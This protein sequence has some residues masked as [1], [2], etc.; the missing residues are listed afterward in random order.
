MSSVNAKASV[1]AT[2][3]RV[4][5]PF[6][7]LQRQCMTCLLWEDNYYIDGVSVAE[8]IK[9]NMKKITREQALQILHESKDVNHLR[10]LPLYLL[11][12]MAENKM[13]KK[14][15]VYKTITRVDDMAEL[16]S[17]WWK[18]TPNGEKKRP[19]SMSIRKGIQ[20]AF[21]KF[22]EYQFGKYKGN[23]KAMK[24]RDVIRIVRPTP[25][26][27]TQSS[28]WKKIVDGTL[29]VPDTW[30]T[31]LS[32]NGEKVDK[33]ATWN[34]LLE[35][36]RLPS[37]ALLRN[38]RNLEQNNISRATIKSKIREAN[39]SKILPFQIVGAWRAAPDL[40]DELEEKLFESI[41][42][43]GHLPGTTLFMVDVSGSMNANLSSKSNLRRVDVA[44]SVAAIVRQICDDALCFSFN[45][46]AMKLPTRR[47]FGLIDAILRNVDGGTDVYGC[48]KAVL[49]NYEH[50]GTMI[51]RV[52][53]ITDEQDR[54]ITG[55]FSG[56]FGCSS[57]AVAS[58]VHF[59]GRGYIVNVGCDERGVF[60]QRSSKWIHINGWSDGVVKYIQSCE[61]LNSPTDS[62]Q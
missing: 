59:K 58:L 13:L 23:T 7:L 29:A 48:L 36:N 21:T 44:A 12:C 53:L 55:G 42:T 62:N 30:E 61:N 45:T 46:N 41:K 35:E 8:S 10:H 28:L 43:M 49:D 27:E 15:D 17:L 60:Y 26:D 37:L 31:A 33:R 22:D 25:K 11:V 6:E 19:L 47:G 2:K 9:E 57:P 38:L 4:L 14:E 5:T 20:M 24:L 18:D 34:R 56:Y 3:E 39:M 51:D 1:E 16:L 54:T 32:G 50:T 52:I 40:E